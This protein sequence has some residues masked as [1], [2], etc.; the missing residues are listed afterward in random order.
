LLE[1]REVLLADFLEKNHP[2]F[3][4]NLYNK[5]SSVSEFLHKRGVK[6]GLYRGDFNPNELSLMNNMSQNRYVDSESITAERIQRVKGN[7]SFG[8]FYPQ[9]NNFEPPSINYSHGLKIMRGIDFVY[10]NPTKIIKSNFILYG[11]KFLDEI[12][13]SHD[14]KEMINFK[15][16]QEDYLMDCP[17]ESIIFKGNAGSYIIPSASAKNSTQYAP[18]VMQPLMYDKGFF[19]EE[20]LDYWCSCE[21]MNHG[22]KT[23]REFENLIEMDKHLNA[24]LVGLRKGK[25]FLQNYG[26]QVISIQKPKGRDVENL[27]IVTLF[28]GLEDLTLPNGESNL[29]SKD[30]G[31]LI[32]KMYYLDKMPMRQVDYF[33][34]NNYWDLIIS[35]SILFSMVSFQ[36][37]YATRL[38][39]SCLK[40]GN[41]YK[42]AKN[43]P[44]LTYFSNEIKA[45]FPSAK[46][47]NKVIKMDSDI[48]ISLSPLREIKLVQCSECKDWNHPL[49]K[50][51]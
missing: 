31:A 46:I 45:P 48:V 41:I 8:E 29:I 9:I 22:S 51:H 17:L 26:H 11:E 24:Y 20:N 44:E 47:K 2:A 25:S 13:L 6:N 27:P 42:I 30:L 50:C 10:T 21:G 38:K 12:S 4:E 34:L 33:L 36:Q 7:Y 37:D 1:C 15:A 23:K 16:K 14:E 49:K 40:G 35:P 32:S 43:N 19:F 18:G 3:L 5:Y 39:S 28:Q